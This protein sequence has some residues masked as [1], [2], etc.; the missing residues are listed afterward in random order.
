MSHS[1][2]QTMQTTIK[3]RSVSAGPFSRIHTRTDL[4]A[5]LEYAVLPESGPSVLVVFGFEG[6]KE[7]LELV[8]AEDGDMLLGRLAERLASAVG[9]TAVL[10]EPR[11]G[12]FCGVFDGPLSS[13]KPLLVTI[14]SELDEEGRSFAIRSSL[15]IA[16]LP[17]EATD[18]TYAIALADHRLR[19][20]SGNLR[21][22]PVSHPDD[23]E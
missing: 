21:P 10:Y 22:A 4:F 16:A 3:A 12:E 8:S 13:I 2:S 14:P 6:L 17:T 5:D 15:G 11:R 18:P 7:H 20:L 9:T 19:A 23:P 1:D